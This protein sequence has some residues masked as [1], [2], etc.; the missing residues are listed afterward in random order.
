M[1]F[2][3]FQNYKKF[4]R[5]YSSTTSIFSTP[6]NGGNCSGGSETIT[7]TFKEYKNIFHQIQVQEELQNFM[8]IVDDGKFS[9]LLI[10]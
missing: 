6:L 4:S 8:S 2:V 3:S 5:F 7:M 9:L 10:L 1:K